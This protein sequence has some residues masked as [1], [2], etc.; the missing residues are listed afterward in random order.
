[1]CPLCPRPLSLFLPKTRVL[2]QED[3][4]CH[5]LSFCLDQCHV[6]S[7]CPASDDTCRKMEALS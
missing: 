2:P 5:L 6:T 4:A 3:I 1:M 7:K